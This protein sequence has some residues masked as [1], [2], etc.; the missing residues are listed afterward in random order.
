MENVSDLYFE[1]FDSGDFV[2]LEPI[3]PE[4]YND[5][6]QDDW[7]KNWI[8]TKVTVKGGAFTGQFFADF[9]TIDF[10][11]F[12]RGIKNLD[13]DFTGKAKFETL[14]GQLT[15]NIEGDGIGHFEIKCFAEDRPGNGSR[16]SFNFTFDQTALARLINE[17]DNITKAFPII[18]NMN[19]KNE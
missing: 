15:L 18:G 9:T 12:K 7:D 11:I 5:E 3:K 4:N 6:L 10:E 14:E 8:R 16:L 2:R 13:N 17:L 1:I 19:I